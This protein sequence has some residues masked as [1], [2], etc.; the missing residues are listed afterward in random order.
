M[1]F[2]E[3]YGVCDSSMCKVWLNLWKKMLVYLKGRR[4]LLLGFFEFD[5]GLKEECMVEIGSICWFCVLMVVV[6]Y[7]VW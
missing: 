7:L 4:I 1:F 3:G 2:S 6:W 5:L